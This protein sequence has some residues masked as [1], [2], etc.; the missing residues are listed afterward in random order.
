MRHDQCIALA[1]AAMPLRSIGRRR[2]EKRISARYAVGNFVRL[3]RQNSGKL[4]E[5]FPRIRYVT[6]NFA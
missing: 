3:F 4:T 6:G 5:D 2:R 1:R